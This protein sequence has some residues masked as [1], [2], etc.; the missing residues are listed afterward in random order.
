VSRGRPFALNRVQ[1]GSQE[2]SSLKVGVPGQDVDGVPDAGAVVTVDT[3]QEPCEARVFSRGHGLVGAPVAGERAGAVLGITLDRPG[4]DEDEFD[5]LL[6]YA[7]GSG[8]ILTV[9]GGFDGPD[10]GV[11]DPPAGFDGSFAAPYP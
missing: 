4:L 9:R 7:P 1:R 6:A 10:P 11:L 2:D 3:R 5:T 8:D